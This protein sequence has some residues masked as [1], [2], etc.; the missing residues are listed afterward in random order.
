MGMN[1]FETEA[2]V[3]AGSG[4]VRW[5]Y[6]LVPA[7]AAVDMLMVW[8]TVQGSSALYH[9]AAYGHLGNIRLTSELSAFLAII[10]LFTNVLQGRYRIANYLTPQGQALDAF[11]MWSIALIAFL[12]FA[13]MA[14]VIDNYSRAVVLISYLAGIPVIALAR[15]WLAQSVASA[16][17]AGRIATERVLIVGRE[18]DVLGFVSR[19]R[20]WNV[21]FV[22]VDAAFLDVPPAAHP[23]EAVAMLKLRLEDAKMRVRRLRPDSVYIAAPWSEKALI[24]HCAQAFMSVPAAIHLA[25]EEIMDRFQKPRI[26]RIGGLSSLQLTRAALSPFEVLVKRGFDLIVAAL[27]LV[28]LAPA[29]A[30]VALA[31]RIEGAGPVFFTQRRYGFNQNMFRIYKFRTM[32]ASEDGHVVTQARRNDPRVTRVG[33]FLR[34]YNLDELPQLINVLSGDMSLVGPRPHAVV[35]D[36]EFEEKIALYARRHNVK[37]GI[38]GWAQVNGLRG[39]TET[40]D[41]MRRRVDHDL[42]YI[43]NWSLGLDVLILLRTLF[44]ASAYRNAF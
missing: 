32:T 28:L 22:I 30:L 24:E 12:A 9:A 5:R 36:D 6:W 1:H 16:S 43:D 15:R 39:P 11:K 33:R 18:N 21:G 14:K 31:L 38:T 10:F 3:S 4:R 20:P 13:F 37:P 26:T 29:F 40:D 35:H 42:W 8:L 25:P 41:K 7:L 44:S 34:R 27:A 23:D 17:R 2:L 19:H